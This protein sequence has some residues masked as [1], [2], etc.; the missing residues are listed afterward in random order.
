[1]SGGLAPA[2]GLDLLERIEAHA[3]Q[4]WPPEVLEIRDDGW[5]LRATPGL[6]RAARIT[7]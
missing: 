7:R 2:I 1:V 3:V 6:G 4:A 5:V